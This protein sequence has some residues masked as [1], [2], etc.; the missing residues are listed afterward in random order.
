MGCIFLWEYNT[1]TRMLYIYICVYTAIYSKTIYHNQFS[2]WWM[3]GGYLQLARR[4]VCAC[5]KTIGWQLVVGNELFQCRRETCA[6]GEFVS[7][8]SCLVHTYGMTQ[9]A[10]LRHWRQNY[11]LVVWWGLKLCFTVV[12]GGYRLVTV[13]AHGD[14]VMLPHWNTRPPAPAIPLSCII[15]TLS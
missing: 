3:G 7:L 15:M 10:E 9:I 2:E 1:Y 14:F 13:D 12:V 8:Y 6:Y 4:V 5:N 11:S